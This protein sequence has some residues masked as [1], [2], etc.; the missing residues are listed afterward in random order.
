MIMV[1]SSR[2]IENLEYKIN[3]EHRMEDNGLFDI[4]QLIFQRLFV[5][6]RVSV[7]IKI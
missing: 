2:A 3:Q 5:H 4:L 7:I 1:G 6:M